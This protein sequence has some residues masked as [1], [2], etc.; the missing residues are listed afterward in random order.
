[1][2][3]LTDAV[4]ERGPDPP[5][6]VQERFLAPATHPVKGEARQCHGTEARTTAVP[7]NQKSAI[8]QKNFKLVSGTNTPKCKLRD[9]GRPSGDSGMW[10][11]LSWGVSIATPAL[12]GHGGWREGRCALLTPT[13]NWPPSERDPGM[14]PPT[15]ASE[16]REP[17]EIHSVQ[18]VVRVQAS[19]RSG[20]T[21]ERSR[22]GVSGNSREA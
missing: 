22:T 21:D 20:C 3:Q 8:F 11:L 12:G 14:P 1:M 5:T 18:S 15:R 13:A 19:R 9:T 17:L 2:G 10:S 6:C 4:T 7:Q 16:D